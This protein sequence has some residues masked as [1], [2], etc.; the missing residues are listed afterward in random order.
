MLADI[1]IISDCVETSVIGVQLVPAD[2]FL[3]LARVKTYLVK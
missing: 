3:K 2:V 1:E